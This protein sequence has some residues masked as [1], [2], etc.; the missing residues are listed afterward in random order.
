MRRGL[1]LWLQVR[2]PKQ[3]GGVLRRGG[4]K[5][6]ERHATRLGD[7]ASDEHDVAWLIAL[8]AEGRRREIGAV[9]LDENALERRPGGDRAQLG[10]LG[11]GDRPGEGEAETEV[12]RVTR[13]RLI[14]DEAVEDAADTLAMGP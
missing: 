8:A 2:Q 6:F 14:A 10:V 3:R 13:H 7:L 5:V 1:L 11:E 4:G 9:G 12:E